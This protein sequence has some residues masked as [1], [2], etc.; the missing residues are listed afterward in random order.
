MRE[1]VASL[2]AGSRHRNFPRIPGR[3]TI[4]AMNKNKMP[5]N[6][7]NTQMVRKVA[8]ANIVAPGS[9]IP[10]PAKTSLNAGPMTQ[11]H[12]NAITVEI[13]NATNMTMSGYVIMLFSLVQ[14][15][16]CRW[17]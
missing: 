15:L 4:D 2:N 6:V 5:S 13:R 14:T 7:G 12:A 9:I 17:K 3:K 10:M 1:M 11:L 16:F 8:N